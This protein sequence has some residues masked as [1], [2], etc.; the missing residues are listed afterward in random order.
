VRLAIGR[1]GRVVLS[2]LAVRAAVLAASIAAIS[3]LRYAT[4]PQTFLHELSLRL[5]YV[6][7]LIGAY[8]Y[9]AVGGLLIAS[10]SSVAYVHRILDAG[11]VFDA[12]RY[13]EVVVF[14]VIGLSVGM[15]ASAQ[16][17]VT[18]R[19]QRTAATLEL[20]NRELRESYEQIRRIDRLKT[21]GEVAAGLAHEIRH[22]LASICGAL[23]IIESRSIDGSPEGEFSRLAMAEVQR[24][25]R[26]V[27]EFLRY[28]RP[29]DPELRAMPLHEVV[30]QVVTLLRVE[31]ERAQVVLELERQAIVEVA[32]DP[33]QIEQV[34]LNVILNAIQ[35]TPSG[36]RVAI[37]EHVDNHE[38]VIDVVDEGPGIA[39]D[40][41]P[42]IFSPFFT[43]KEKGTGLGLAIAHHI[44]VAHRGRLEVHQTSS[45]G[46]T[47]RICLP[48][49]G[50]SGAVF[51]AL[52]PEVAG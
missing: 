5:Y 14:Y 52:R 38:A 20:A 41:L 30:A 6:P 36:A 12:S 32:I 50:T 16:R 48:A 8:W 7:I 23:E 10:V 29:H 17:S 45:R 49:G 19:Y 18:A 28:A 3:F 40:H 42:S 35:A 2:A 43:T 44:V 27:W 47:V 15:L 33:L 46:T 37:L 11:P 21:L 25:D 13:S 31:A 39:A 9:G 26:L 4:G 51:S 22:P 34:L 24:L 1:L